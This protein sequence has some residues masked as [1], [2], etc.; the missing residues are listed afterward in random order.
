M[1]STFSVS[2]RARSSEQ[3][4]PTG[5]PQ[6]GRR[7]IYACLQLLLSTKPWLKRRLARRTQAVLSQSFFELKTEAS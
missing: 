5:M 2:A 4:L 1:R 3:Q 6:R 7:V